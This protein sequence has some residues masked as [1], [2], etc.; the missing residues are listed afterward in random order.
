MFSPKTAGALH[1]IAPTQRNNKFL[2]IMRV[3]L[4]RDTRDEQTLFNA[5]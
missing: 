5:F 2:A 1:T 4:V 3:T